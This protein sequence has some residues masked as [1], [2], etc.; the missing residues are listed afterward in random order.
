MSRLS[1]WLLF[2]LGQ[3]VT[4]DEALEIAR[5][6]CE[7]RGTP[8]LEPIKVYR[9]YGDWAIWTFASRRGGNVRVVIDGGTGEVKRL[10]GPTPR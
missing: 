10:E 9:H 4:R 8:W 7:A 6:V 1:R 3:D 2:R 5:A